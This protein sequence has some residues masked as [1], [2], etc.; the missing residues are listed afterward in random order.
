MSTSSAPFLLIEKKKTGIRKRF[1]HSW[2]IR[3]QG[4]KR[5]AQEKFE[6]DVLVQTINTL[7]DFEILTTLFLVYSSWTY[8]YL[9]FLFEWLLFLVILLFSSIYSLKAVFIDPYFFNYSEFSDLNIHTHPDEALLFLGHLILLPVVF[10]VYFFFI[11][12]NLSI[13]QKLFAYKIRK[14]LCARC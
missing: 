14:W 1:W 11:W 10:F 5:I 6:L 7:V 13:F 8:T 12:P 2:A 4:S 9:W 3:V